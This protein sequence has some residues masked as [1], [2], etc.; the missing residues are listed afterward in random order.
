[1]FLN[2]IAVPSACSAMWPGVRCPPELFCRYG[3]IRTYGRLP[4]ETFRAIRAAWIPSSTSCGTSGTCWHASTSFSGTQPPAVRQP[5]LNYE[6]P[7][8]S[9]G[10]QREVP[11][12]NRRAS[13]VP[14]ARLQVGHSNHSPLSARG[15][16]LAPL[17]RLRYRRPWIREWI[18]EFLLTSTVAECSKM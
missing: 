2:S 12:P 5:R 10:M 7:A 13:G 16:G 14:L 17:G 15:I 6:T 11:L 18:R 4:S 8:V 3:T 1:M 9:Q